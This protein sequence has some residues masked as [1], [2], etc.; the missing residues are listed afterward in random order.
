MRQLL[1]T[2]PHAEPVSDLTL[3]RGRC[4][5]ESADLREGAEGNVLRKRGIGLKDLMSLQD[6]VSKRV[7]QDMQ[8]FA[9]ESIS[10]SQDDTFKVTMTNATKVATKVLRTTKLFT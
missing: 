4:L 5:V 10:A 6:E 8:R 9:A 3:I 2:N 1:A 7:S